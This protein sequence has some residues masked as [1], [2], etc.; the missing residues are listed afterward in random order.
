LQIASGSGA[1]PELLSATVSDDVTALLIIPAMS[2]GL[3]VPKM[4]LDS[5]F[6]DRVG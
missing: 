6:R 3:I 5:R 1:T 4:L 2:F